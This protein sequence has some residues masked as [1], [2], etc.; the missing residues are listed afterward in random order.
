[1]RFYTKQHKAYCGIDL[2]AR[3]M[4]LCILNQDGEI[5]LHRNMKASPEALLKAVAPYRDDLVIAVECVF[6]WYWL[7]D[8]CARE[9]IPFVLGH[10]LYMKAIHGGKAKNDKI[11]AHKIAVLLRGG[12]LP[13]AYVYPATM[14]A[15]RDLLRRRMHLVRKRAE[16]LAHVQN[17]H[18]QYNLA[19][20]SK[21]IAYQANRDGLVERFAEPAVQ[22][23][24]EIDL[25]L[26]A[27]DDQ[28][29]NDVE[30]YI[31]KTAKQH[32]PQTFYRLQSVP[33]IGKI[34][35]LVLLYEIHDIRRFP[36]VQD[37][38]SYCR[39]VKCAKESAGKRYGT[40]GA[41]IGNAYLKWAFSE[42]A[43][44]FLR[45]NPAGQKYLARLE[46][47]HGPGKALSVLAHKLG[48]AVYYM[49]RRQTA[50]DLQK[51]CQR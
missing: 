50:F 51:F 25:A 2:H 6:T 22:K 17:T 38:A 43:V 1:M 34:L 29:L 41:K 3:T 24:I 27:Y 40:A 26:I 42:A 15:T 12:M 14:R 28:L 11:D 31:V 23:T 13:Q 19:A 36:R 47:Q 20:L 21:N 44:L 7:A 37:F 33:G 48:R 35:S 39:L 5:M 18:S 8:L 4:Y 9:G 10:A 16:L 30:L 32:D 46:N 49:L 45:D